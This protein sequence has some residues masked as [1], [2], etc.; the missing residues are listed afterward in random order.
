MTGLD[1]D[2]ANCH[3]LGNFCLV[4]LVIK[5]YQPPAPSIDLYKAMA[6]LPFRVSAV[7]VIVKEAVSD[8]LAKEMCI[9]LQLHTPPSKFEVL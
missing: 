5:L 3:L 4:F 8:D 1:I 2:S 6:T 7:E 9:A